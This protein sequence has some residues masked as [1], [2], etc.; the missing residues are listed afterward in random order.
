M[1]SST[2][3]YTTSPVAWKYKQERSF[4]SFIIGPVGSGKSVPSL[5]RILDLG[6]EQAPSDD[7]KPG[8]LLNKRHCPML[9][10]GLMGAWQDLQRTSQFLSVGSPPMASGITWS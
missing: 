3:D 10:K 5:Q 8:L 4:A 2:W 7:G 9:H 6:Q 1:T